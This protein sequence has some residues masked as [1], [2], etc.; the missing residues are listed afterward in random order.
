MSKQ[1]IGSGGNG[2]AV[3][4]GT[5]AGSRKVSAVDPGAVSRIGN[6][7]VATQPRPLA[8]AKP[9]AVPLGN[10]VAKNVGA[11]GPGKGR[12]VH[13]TGTQGRH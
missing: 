9:A 7:V 6:Q 11:G 10:E 3:N 4:V 5:V 8:T 12:T 2:K 1:K 13:A